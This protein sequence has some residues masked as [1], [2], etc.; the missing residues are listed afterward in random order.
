MHVRLGEPTV[1]RET[2]HPHGG[3]HRNQA[4]APP[5]VW[6]RPYR[7]TDRSAVADMSSVLSPGSLYQRFF[8][9]YPRLPTAFL[10]QLDRSLDGPN[11]VLV[12]HVDAAHASAETIRREAVVV[13]VGELVFTDTAPLRAELGVLV[14]DTHHRHGIGLRIVQGLLEQA[15]RRGVSTV[16]ADALSGNRAVQ[17]LV[18]TRYPQACATVDG[19]VTRYELDLADWLRR[20]EATGT[21]LG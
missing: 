6:V 3:P 1:A 11:V 19:L 14:A 13:G 15:H 7:A 8:T 20:S 5:T 12:A 21:M 4:C 2:T 10:E 17:T 16:S 18:R 9:G